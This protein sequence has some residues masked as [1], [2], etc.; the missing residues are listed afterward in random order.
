MK[1]LLYLLL[2]MSSLL[3]LTP[4]TAQAA[5]RRYTPTDSPAEA[6]RKAA[7]RE[8]VAAAR[9][10]ATEKRS[11]KRLTKISKKMRHAMRVLLGLE[12]SKTVTSPAKLNRQLHAHQKQLKAKARH[13]AR[14]HRVRCV[15]QLR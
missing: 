6:E 8:K 4:R 12:E 1:K 11:A 9:K 10:V 15:K 5:L 7:A 14:V 13:Q 3:A 2:A